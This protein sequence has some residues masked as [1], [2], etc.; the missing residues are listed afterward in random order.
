MHTVKANE[1]V[2]TEANAV[3]WVNPSIDGDVKVCGTVPRPDGWQSPHVMRAVNMPLVPENEI[4]DRIR[5]NAAN[6]SQL[7]D[8]WRRMNAPVLD[9]NGRGYCWAHSGT[10]AVQALRAAANLPTVPLSAYA[11]ACVIKNYRDEGGWGAQGLDF[12]SERGVPSE[13][14]WPMKAVSRSHDNPRTWE[15]AALHR[16]TE[17]WVDTVT[18]QYDRDLSRLQVVTLLL[19]RIPVIGDYNW[20]GHSVCLLDPVVLPSGRIGVRIVNSWGSSWSDGG[21]GVLDDR[22]AW[23]D[24]ATAPRVSVASV[25]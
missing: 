13:S 19:N 18:P 8:I 20:W 16:V 23:P 22:K 4:V 5:E 14:F 2:I 12:I 21:M 24:G 25:V 15:N 6:G 1:V 10:S 3:N 17:G 9:Q 11:V 7:S